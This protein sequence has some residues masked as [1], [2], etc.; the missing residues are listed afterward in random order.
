[1][2]LLASYKQ[3]V[4]MFCLIYKRWYYSWRLRLIKD[5]SLA[6]VA[7]NCKLI[8]DSHLFTMLIYHAIHLYKL[9]TCKPS[10]RSG[11][12]SFAKVR[13]CYTLTH[14][15]THS[16]SYIHTH[17]CT[18][19]LTHTHTHSHSHSRTHSH[20]RIHSHSRNMVCCTVYINNLP[21]II[22]FSKYKIFVD[23]K[24]VFYDLFSLFH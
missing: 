15:H 7:Q 2:V 4:M 9:L 3:M 8:I 18:H 20:A 13:S 10:P 6:N 17:A 1:M 24:K 21:G 5:N 22:K 23:D 14:T 12:V 16:H 19:T 11:I